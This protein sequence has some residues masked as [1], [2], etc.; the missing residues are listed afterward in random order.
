MTARLGLLA[1][2]AAFAVA[3]ACGAG[4][5]VLAGAAPACTHP[6]A[7]G[8]AAAP[9]AALAPVR[10]AHGDWGADQI[11]NAATIVAVGA[12]LGVPARGQLIAVAAAIQE[13]HL[14]NTPGGDRDSIGLFQQRPSQG[15]G[16]AQQLRDPASAAAKFYAK[17]LTIPGWQTMPL[18]DAAQAVQ[19]S[20]T[21]HAYRSWEPD[22]GTLV[23]AIAAQTGIPDPAERTQCPGGC[24][25]ASTSQPAGRPAPDPT[26]EPGPTLRTPP[27]G[28]RPPPDTPPAVATAVGWALRQL[29]TPYHYG[30]DCTDPHSGDA[31]HQCDCSSLVQQAY[32]AAGI[33][34]PRTATA[35][36]HV[37]TPIP[38]PDQ[39]QPGDLLLIPGGD[40]TPSS[41]GHVG[42][43]LGDRLILD[44]PHTGAVVH[45]SPITPYWLTD[46]TIRRVVSS[47]RSRQG[48]RVL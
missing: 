17:L 37:G 12:A 28:Y 41:P 30:G 21:P 25:H 8:A 34:L 29:G 9:A 47:P 35:Q 10:T 6:P 2:S 40:G 43:Y 22:A 38:H 7:A 14:A 27:A 15:W 31:A 26:C 24:P 33:S 4:I 42:L 36:S 44:A 23:A 48:H 46:L 45:I 3:S 5:A 39:L 32:H 19:H 11:G 1:A 20:A 13:S 18:T 16:T